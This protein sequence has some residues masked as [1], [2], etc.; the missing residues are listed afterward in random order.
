MRFNSEAYNKLYP[1]IE[2]PEK[3][4]TA[5]ELFTP[6]KDIIEDKQVEVADSIPEVVDQKGVVNGDN[7]DNDS[8]DN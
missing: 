7:G 5:V 3:I 1:R 2:E 4:E 8:A 6:T